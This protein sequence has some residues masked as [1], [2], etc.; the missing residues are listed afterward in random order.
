MPRGRPRKNTEPL[1]PQEVT[2]EAVLN[3]PVVISEHPLVTRQQELLSLRE[4]M[5][6]EGVDSISKLDALLSQV[7]EEV[8]K[9]A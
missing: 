6:R 9:L 7:N 1:D 3:E 8:R 2:E 4:A 5:T